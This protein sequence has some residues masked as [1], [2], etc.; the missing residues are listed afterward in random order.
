MKKINKNILQWS[1]GILI[2]LST[3]TGIGYTYVLQ[4]QICNLI[5]AKNTNLNGKVDI[6]LQKIDELDKKT[7]A[8]QSAN[9]IKMENVLGKISLIQYRLDEKK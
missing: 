9:D 6:M 4:P 2:S 7:T 1:V 5:D 3:L 8:S